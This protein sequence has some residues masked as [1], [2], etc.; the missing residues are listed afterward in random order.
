MKA[1]LS[2]LKGKAATDII[3]AIFSLRVQDVF[4]DST[5]P[6]GHVIPFKNAALLGEFDLCLGSV[7]EAEGNL[8]NAG[9][10]IGMA[11][12]GHEHN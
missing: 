3:G 2:T 10:F 11:R 4:L 6:N 9:G 8:E 5:Y 12:R 7:K 1:L